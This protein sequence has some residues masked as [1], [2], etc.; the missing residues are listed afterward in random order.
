MTELESI[1]K[2]TDLQLLRLI[3]GCS[4]LARLP[5][6]GPAARIIRLRWERTMQAVRSGAY[7][8]DAIELSRRIISELLA[9]R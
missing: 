5:R 8:V 1:R 7:R 6:L 4:E 3:S 2:Q 9:S